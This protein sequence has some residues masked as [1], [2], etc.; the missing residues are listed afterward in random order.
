MWDLIIR[1]KRA[2]SMLP[3]LET[4]L[5]AFGRHAPQITDEVTIAPHPAQEKR[6]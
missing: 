3:F 2:S 4:I 5:A 1:M 6:Y